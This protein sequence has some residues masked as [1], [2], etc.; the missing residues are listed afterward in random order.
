[1]A[2]CCMLLPHD[3]YRVPQLYKRWSVSPPVA[4]NIEFCGYL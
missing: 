1:M 3:P 4:V 2:V